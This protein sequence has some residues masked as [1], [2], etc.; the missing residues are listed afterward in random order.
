MT[1]PTR[2]SSWPVRARRTS[3]VPISSC[4]EAASGRPTCGRWKA[5]PRP[6]RGVAGAQCRD[7]HSQLLNTTTV[8]LA[9]PTETRPGERRVALVPDVVKKLVAAGWDVVVQSGAGT[10]AAFSDNG[11]V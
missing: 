6:D 10:E 11:Y 3:L 1:W 8:K 4:T 2:A 9:V 7:H 5:P